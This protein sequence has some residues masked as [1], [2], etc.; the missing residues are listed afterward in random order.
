MAHRAQ[1]AFARAISAS[2]AP[3]A[4]T[5]KNSSGSADWQAASSHQLPIPALVVIAAPSCPDAASCPLR[6]RLHAFGPGKLQNRTVMERTMLADAAPEGA[7]PPG[8]R[9]A[10]VL[11]GGGVLGA[12][13]VGM[14]RA[15]LESGFRPDMV[16]GT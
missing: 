6:C 7:V 4:P 2:P 5:G 16:I 11:G 15:L 1:M 9:S 13:Q 10:I 3:G 8:G 12:T 14:L